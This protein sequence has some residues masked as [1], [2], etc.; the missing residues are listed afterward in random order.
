MTVIKKSE[1][2][3]YQ[4]YKGDIWIS[5]Q[6]DREIQ[7]TNIAVLQKEEFKVLTYVI[8]N[9]DTFSFNGVK[10]KGV[11]LD[12]IVWRSLK[13]IGWRDSYCYTLLGIEKNSKEE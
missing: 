11:T 4:H 5:E 10:S 2:G 6:T 3:R 9:G 13:M 1:Y 12:E 8:R 7:G